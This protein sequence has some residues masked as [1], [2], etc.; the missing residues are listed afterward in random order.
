M[1]NKEMRAYMKDVKKRQKEIRDFDK[2]QRRG[3]KKVKKLWK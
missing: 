2:E 1:G 3:L